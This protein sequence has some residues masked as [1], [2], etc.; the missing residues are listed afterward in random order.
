MHLNIFFNQLDRALFEYELIFMFFVCFDTFA[1]IPKQGKGRVNKK[2]FFKYL[3]QLA[4]T[5]SS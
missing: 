5:V 2:H 1:K 3:D 4:Y